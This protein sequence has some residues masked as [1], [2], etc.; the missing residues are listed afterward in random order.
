MR[1]QTNERGLKLKVLEFL[2]GP[3]SF[4]LT[5][6]VFLRLLGLTYLAAF[7]SLWPQIVGLMGSHGVVPIAE[8]I[9]TLH[10][11]LGSKA[12]LFAPSLFWFRIS[13]GLL[14]GSCVI[15]CITG[16][17]MTAGIL[18]R[19]CAAMSWF[20]YLSIVAVGQPF[21][22]FQWDA[23]LLE[24]G[25]LAV[26][27]GAPWLGWAYRFLLFRLMFESGLVKLLSGDPNWRNLHALRFHFLT[28]PLPSPLAYYV[29]RAPAWL[30]DGMTACTLVIELIAPFLLF[31]PLSARRVGVALLMALQFGIILT[32]N[33][34]FFNFLTLALCIWGLDDQTFAPLVRVLTVKP[35]FNWP[36]EPLGRGVR[37][38]SNSILALIIVVG[39]LQVIQMLDP[40]LAIRPARAFLQFIAPFEIVNTYGLFATM[41]TTRPEI[42]LQGSNDQVQ[43][44]AYEFRYK[45]GELHRGLP[46]V[47]PHQP[48]LDWQMWFAALG[49]FAE[50]QWVGSLMYRLM[51]G[52]PTVMNLLNRSPFDKPPRYMRALLYDYTFTEPAQRKR[53]GTVWKRELQ[54]RWFGPVSLTGR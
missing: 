1:Q 53:T 40:R 31:C 3:S 29:Y 7:G 42:I 22:N 19:I 34:A 24:A 39:A 45:P 13:D 11:E 32:G 21:M 15:G 50:N 37:I 6:S 14:T 9:T 12:F 8:T 5:E 52:E 10:S 54:G 51:V 36:S 30:L 26:F 48:R 46:L 38:V 35:R 28:Q 17:L 44:R 16:L 27:A 33:Y 47:A 23:L 41:T 25:F 2:G 4:A 49:T 18:S 43:W 20:L